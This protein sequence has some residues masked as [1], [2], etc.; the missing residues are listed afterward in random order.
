MLAMR[1]FVFATAYY[2]VL[3]IPGFTVSQIITNYRQNHSHGR[4]AERIHQLICSDYCGVKLITWIMRATTF[5]FVQPAYFCGNYSSL[6]L[7]AQPT[8]SKQ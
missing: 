4:A 8:M 6:G 1:L 7:V 3:F 5:G 2:G